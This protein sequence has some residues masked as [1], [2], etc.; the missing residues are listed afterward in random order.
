M[1]PRSF[2]AGRLNEHTCVIG[3]TVPTHKHCA[4]YN[5]AFEAFHGMEVVVGKIELQADRIPE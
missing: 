5:L 4:I 2:S 1:R 3:Q